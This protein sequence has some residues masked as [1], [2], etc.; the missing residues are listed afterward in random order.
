MPG[1][2]RTSF[3]L[4]R[5]SLDSLR[6]RILADAREANISPS[7]WQEKASLSRLARSSSGYSNNTTSEIRQVLT[8]GN[9]GKARIRNAIFAKAYG[10]AGVLSRV[11]ETTDNNIRNITNGML[12]A[13]RAIAKMRMDM[14]AGKLY[15][16]DISGAFAEEVEDL[17][18]LRV[19]RRP[20]ETE[21][22]Q[23]NM[24]GD[25]RSELHKAL[26]R[27]LDRSSR[28]GKRISAFLQNYADLVRA[29][30]DPR[31]RSLFPDSTPPT[32]YELAARAISR[33]EEKVNGQ[34]KDL[35]S[36][37]REDGSDTEKPNNRGHGGSGNEVGGEQRGTAGAGA[38]EAE[39]ADAGT[40]PNIPLDGGGS[41]TGSELTGTDTPAPGSA[42]TAAKWARAKARQRRPERPTKGPR[43]SQNGWRGRVVTDA[44][45]GHIL[46]ESDTTAY[47]TARE[48]PGFS[49]KYVENAEVGRLTTDVK[50]VSS[51][52][53]AAKIL[54]P[55]RNEAQ[56]VLVALVTDDKGAPLG[57][58]KVGKGG[59]RSQTIDLKL[60]LG[61]VHAMDGSAHLW[62]AHNHPL[63]QHRV[64]QGRPFYDQTHR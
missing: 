1:S 47:V 45:G 26:L 39:S 10:D 12:Q 20:V 44:D 46:K 41:G 57:V 37:N 50:Q 55:F 19:E 5:P 24:L 30:G 59:I 35:L 61:A 25:K 18:R 63:R 9:E 52:V 11:V 60:L 48:A 51:A 38:P 21:L 31:Q 53:D 13:A 28:S 15:N 6:D 34:Q 17:G 62:Y 49:K 32:E 54:A 36:G 27:F 29:A 40:P 3:I 22:A 23:L 56:E 64:Q 58:V 43:I 42:Q 8:T 33:A 14:A 4:G 16:L 7:A 2:D